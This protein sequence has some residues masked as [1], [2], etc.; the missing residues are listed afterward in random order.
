[1]FLECGFI[2]ISQLDENAAKDLFAAAKLLHPENTLLMIADGY[3]HFTKMQL[4]AAATCFEAVLHKDPHNEMA[5][6]FLGLTYAMSPKTLS[7]GEKILKE[8]NSH[9]HDPA[10]KKLSDDS[11]SFVDMHLKKH[12]PAQGQGK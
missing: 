7:Q 4:G 6:T 11:L 8:T 3:M 1:M 2:A 9:T 12:G 5:K 10:I